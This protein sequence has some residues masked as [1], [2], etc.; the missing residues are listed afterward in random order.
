[1]TRYWFVLLLALLALGS[2]CTAQEVKLMA[3]RDTGFTLYATPY[4][5]AIIR[6]TLKLDSDPLFYQVPHVI[7]AEA[8]ALGDGNGVSC[9]GPDVCTYKHDHC[10]LAAVVEQQ[11]AAE[12]PADAKD[13][14][15]K[16]VVSLSYSCDDV[17]LATGTVFVSEAPKAHVVFAFPQAKTLYGLAEHAADL[18]LR[19]GRSYEM[20]NTD[21]FEYEVNSTAALYGSI[22]FLMAYSA[23][24]TAGV[25]FLNS[26]DTTV[27]MAPEAAGAAP[28]CDWAAEVGPVDV[29][30]MPGPTPARVQ[31]Q[32]ASLTGPTMLPPYFSLGYHQCR[33]N[34]LSTKDCLAIDEGFDKHNM[35]YDVL[36]LDIEHTDKKKYFT[37]DKYSFPDPKLLTDALASKGRKLVTVKDPHVKRETGYH[38]HDQAT[39]EGLY[40]QNTGGEAYVGDCWPGQSSW[41]DFYNKR[42]R[43]W[44]ASLFHDSNYPGG[45][46][47]IHT[48]V[49]MNEPS[50]FKAPRNTMHK[51]AVHTDDAGNKIEHRYIHN[52][53]SLFS[54][55]ATYQGSLE[56]AGPAAQ[57]KRE[58]PFI[59]TRS[60]FPGSQRYGA[61]WNGDNMA[62]WAHLQNT[63]PELL[64]LSVSNFPFC[65]CDVGGF[66]HNPE[67][68]L[69]V[70]WMQAGVFYPFLRGH[71]HLETKRRE[72]WTFSEAAQ[73]HIRNALALRYTLVPYLY[74]TFLHAHRDGETVMRPLIY[75]FPAQEA[76]REVQDTFMFGPSLLVAPVVHKGATEKQVVLP[77]GTVW[78]RYQTGEAV[79]GPGTTA[80][81]TV[82]ITL[83]SIPLFLRGGHVLPVKLRLRRNTAA[84]RIDP[85]T[86]LIALNQQG[87]S[88]GDLYLDDGTT[89]D[90][91]S[92]AYAHRQFSFTKGTLTCTA[93]PAAGPDGGISSSVARPA[94]FAVPNAV[95]RIVVMGLA[96]HIASVDA[97]TGPASSSGTGAAG[98]RI[99]RPLEFERVGHAIV[100]RKPEVNVGD[101]WVVTFHSE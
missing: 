66:F 69:F 40:V 86:L 39:K 67:E 5:Q 77:A 91:Q 20:W 62:N 75:E 85:F 2:V 90:Y 13:A 7:V 10:A 29:F 18:A 51:H 94:A 28:E 11:S 64:S 41:P 23:K 55:M 46:R 82:P 30:F 19:H 37:W 49:D 68:E 9:S 45:S 80:G 84:A 33:W 79:V 26:A 32:H 58:R 34:Y 70:R 48:W 3:V 60:F 57:S 14:P 89:F 76:L 56:A 72:P 95:E 47:D 17:V 16:L 35:P 52:A 96:G 54:L 6:A 98:G 15:R 44:Y 73:N 42:T 22:P 93:A 61:M 74:T 78:Y 8:V 99:V 12:A 100:V 81:V 4:R 50:V 1:M 43:D 65:G 27:R 59:L 101:D 53:Y 36:W 31:Q 97:S 83:D 24:A 87:N 63:Q 71:A 21:A 38:V 88:H 25:L 92:G